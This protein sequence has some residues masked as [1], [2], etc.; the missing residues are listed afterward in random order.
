MVLPG[1][2]AP[3]GVQ[4]AAPLCAAQARPWEWVLLAPGMLLQDGAA[5]EADENSMAQRSGSCLA[6]EATWSC[7]PA[8]H[9]HASSLQIV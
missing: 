2:L 1:L 6:A 8:F 5:A 7:C 4:R 3:A 9:M